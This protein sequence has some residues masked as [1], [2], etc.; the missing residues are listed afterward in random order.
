MSLVAVPK[1]QCNE[2]TKLEHKKNPMP[3]IIINLPIA[4]ATTGT[5][6]KTTV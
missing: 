1:P 2:Y 4:G 3:V 6:I 5:S